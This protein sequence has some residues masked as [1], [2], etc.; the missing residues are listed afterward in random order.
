MADVVL[1][2]R[3]ECL[4]PAQVL[5]EIRRDPVSGS[6]Y[7]AASHPMLSVSASV[8]EMTPIEIEL[9]LDLVSGTTS[10]RLGEGESACIAVA[11]ERRAIL[12]IDERKGRRVA[13]ERFPELTF[14]SSAE[15]LQ[16]DSVVEILGADAKACFDKALRLGGMHIV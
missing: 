8:V 7:D 3:R 9:F 15:L 1:A 2:L 13:S 16:L 4:I 14:T 5:N 11:A 6:S 12:A 10:A